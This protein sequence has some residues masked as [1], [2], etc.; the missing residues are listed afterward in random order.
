VAALAGGVAIAAASE[1]TA[2]LLLT[3]IAYVYL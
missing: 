1:R 2:P 3:F